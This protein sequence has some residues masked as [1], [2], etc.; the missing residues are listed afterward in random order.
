MACKCLF[1]KNKKYKF[2]NLFYVTTLLASLQKYSGK[3]RKKIFLGFLLN[4]VYTLIRQSTCHCCRARLP[5]KSLLVLCFVGT[6]AGNPWGSRWPTCTRRSHPQRRRIDSRSS[7]RRRR[8]DTGL[9]SRGTFSQFLLQYLLKDSLTRLWS[10]AVKFYF[11]FL[12]FV[13]WE[14]G[15]GTVRL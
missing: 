9:N 1:L 4:V 15:T 12:D 8:R 11:Y 14:I 13:F 5:S 6:F 10:R 2:F 7:R 3:V